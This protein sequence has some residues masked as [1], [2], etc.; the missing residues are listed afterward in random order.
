MLY[1]YCYFLFKLKKNDYEKNACLLP[2]LNFDLVNE[3][4]I[5]YYYYPS[6]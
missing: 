1:V 2:I 4:I 6:I 5:Y 3:F